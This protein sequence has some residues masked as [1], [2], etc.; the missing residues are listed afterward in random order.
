MIEN[1]NIIYK[2]ILSQNL[3]NFLLPQ[4]HQPQK[5]TVDYDKTEYVDDAD[6][7]EEKFAQS[8]GNCE[9]DS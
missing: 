7:R 2:P 1:E 4:I 8:E 9:Y 6:F 3:I 5:Q